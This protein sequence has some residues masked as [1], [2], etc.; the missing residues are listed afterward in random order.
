M[1]IFLIGYRCTG[2][3]TIGKSLAQQLKFRFMDTDRL[4]ENNSQ[5]SIADIVKNEGWEAFRAL[6]KETLFNTEEI[7]KAV[8]ATGGGIIIDPENRNFLTQHGRTIWLDAELNTVINRLNKD[9]NTCSSRPPLTDQ[10]LLKETRELMKQ[11]K[12]LY[13]STADIKID[14]T[15]Q[16]PEKIIQLIYRRLF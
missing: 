4:I 11:R 16:P 9:K 5:L 7:D 8:I 3:T 6:E 13:E 15:H 14:T 1:K 12:P 2:K 10:N